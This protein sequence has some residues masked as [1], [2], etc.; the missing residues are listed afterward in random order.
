MSKI[1]LVYFVFSLSIVLGDPSP[2]T[3]SRVNALEV[4]RA[5]TT[6]NEPELLQIDRES[7][8]AVEVWIDA[9]D[10]SSEITC[11]VDYLRKLSTQFKLNKH[12]FEMIDMHLLYKSLIEIILETC[13]RKIV[14][15]TVKLSSQSEVQ[16]PA[17]RTIGFVYNRW[18]HGPYD[19][20]VTFRYMAEHMLKMIGYDKRENHDEFM[21]AWENGPCREILNEL[22]QPDM[23][24]LKNFIRMISES[25]LDPLSVNLSRLR[26]RYD[27]PMI[28]FCQYAQWKKALARVWIAL[29]DR[30]SELENHVLGDD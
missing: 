24:S 15:K 7:R 22:E 26:L 14:N 1:Q 28:Q 19:P 17:L 6:G 11:N 8:H 23:E 3:A 13:G 12:R 29:Q 10:V 4:M 30:D 16:G 25:E 18:I 27:I 21:E 2:V 5:L 9:M 20:Q